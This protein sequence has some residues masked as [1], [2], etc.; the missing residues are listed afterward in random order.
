[1]TVSSPEAP[2]RPHPLSD[3]LPEGADVD[4]ERDVANPPEFLFELTEHV[5]TELFDP[6]LHRRQASS[7]YDSLR[8]HH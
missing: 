7:R 8:L 1:M 2:T 3:R 4:I 5:R 6:G